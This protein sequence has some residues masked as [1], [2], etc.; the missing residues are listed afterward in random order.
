MR[1]WELLKKL[2]H[3][4]GGL[5]LQWTRTKAYWEIMLLLEPRKANS[6][7]KSLA[8]R[9]WGGTAWYKPEKKLYHNLHCFLLGSIATLPKAYCVIVFISS[10][11]QVYESFHKVTQLRGF[12]SSHSKG[13]FPVRGTPFKKEILDLGTQGDIYGTG[14]TLD[15]REDIMRGRSLE[16]RR[17]SCFFRCKVMLCQILRME[18]SNIKHFY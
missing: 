9:K 16:I 15:W 18:T 17:V 2:K 6:T 1:T 5:E 10:H 14:R 7:G 3:R 11:W 8:L 12:L 13:E 4:D